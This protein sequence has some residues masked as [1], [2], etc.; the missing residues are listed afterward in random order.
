MQEFVSCT[1]SL[2]IYWKSPVHRIADPHIMTCNYICTDDGPTSSI[3][4]MRRPGQERHLRICSVDVTLVPHGWC[5]IAHAS[6]EHCDDSCYC[7]TGCRCATVSVA[8]HHLATQRTS[9]KHTEHA[10]SAIVTGHSLAQQATASR[11]PE[12]SLR[13][14]APSVGL[15]SRSGT[16]LVRHSLAPALYPARRCP[17]TGPLRRSWLAARC[18]L[19]VSNCRLRLCHSNGS[20]RRTA[21]LRLLIELRPAPHC[22]LVLPSLQGRKL[23]ASVLSRVGRVP[24]NGTSSCRRV[25]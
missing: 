13:Q 3:S 18:T 12:L 8:R 1:P 24:A 16:L 5:S 25:R 15:C 23:P 20:S 21:V 9:L 7:S 4:S 17:P 2:S 19:L 14:P 22:P 11:I 6:Q 10:I